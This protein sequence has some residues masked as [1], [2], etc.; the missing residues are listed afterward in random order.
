MQ[1]NS[2]HFF[3][4]AGLLEGMAISI[5]VLAPAVSSFFTPS[6]ILSAFFTSTVTCQICISVK[7]SLNPGIPVIRMPFSAFQ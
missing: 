6:E 1:L 2:I 3:F 5:G 4:G 7:A